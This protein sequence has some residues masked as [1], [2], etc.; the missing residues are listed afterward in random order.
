M[1]NTPAVG[2]DLGTTYSCVGVFKNNKVTIIANEEGN[3][4]TPSYVAFT[5]SERLV[6]DAA[7]A[8]VTSNPI[9]TIFDVKR[10]IGRNYSDSTVQEDIRHWP[11]KVVDD[12]SKPK[13]EVTFQGQ[14]KIFHPEEISSMV[15]F[16]MKQIAET[17][18]GS[19]VT[20]AVI[21]APAYFNDSQRQATKDAGTIAGLN[22]L[23][24]VNEPTAAA[25]AYG[26][27]K[28]TG[29]EG[30]QPEEQFV[31]VFDLGGGTFD[32]SVLCIEDGIFEVLSTSGNTHLGGEDFDNRL[33]DFCITEFKKKH[34]KDIRENK[35]SLKRLR[36]AVEKAKRTLSSSEEVNIEIDSLMAG[37]DFYQTITR[38]KFEIMCND[39]LRDTLGPVASALQSAGIVKAQIN[40]VVLVG[41]SSR[42]PKIRQLLRDFFNNKELNLSIN[43]DEAIAYGAAVQAAVLTGVKSNVVENVLLL[44]ITP[45]S[46]GLETA[47]GQMTTLIK[48]NTTIPAKATKTFTTFS[49]DQTTVVIQ[50]YEGERPMTKD[51]HLLG[52]FEITDLPPQPRGVP[53]IEVTFEVDGNSILD[54]HAVEVGSGKENAITITNDKGRLNK[55]EV[56]RM[57]HDA[58]AFKSEDQL[59]KERA[60]AKQRLQQ[61]T[62][63]IKDLLRDSAST[64]VLSDVEKYD[65]ATKATETIAW[66]NN[67]PSASTDEYKL[68]HHHLEVIAR[69]LLEKINLVAGP[70]A[71]QQNNPY[72]DDLE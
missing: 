50:I 54:V 59:E 56:E 68:V 46:L 43:P 65:L 35:R 34:K 9:N 17:F 20:D 66:L 51:N 39:L 47:G 72:V 25:I 44:D 63:S 27:D 64:A 33:V 57:I 38:S 42:I 40:E 58:E 32:V 18:L 3:R 26:L 1:S 31:L 61:Y 24:I 36:V 52:K 4:I 48:R 10:L 22:V 5:D 37:L 60:H 2:I 62:T 49:D 14:V 19:I 53:Q 55:S 67:N 28:Q 11:F 45:L 16:K 41:G 71:S 21:T 23:R 15:L 30:G 8:Q 6:G 29:Q 7:K 69:P 70:S 12:N 13:I